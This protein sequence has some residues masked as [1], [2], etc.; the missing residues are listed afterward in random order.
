MTQNPNKSTDKQI[1][2]TQKSLAGK[3]ESYWENLILFT[4]I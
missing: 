2:E 3:N 1:H 4:L